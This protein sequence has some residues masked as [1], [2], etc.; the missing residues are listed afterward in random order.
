MHGTQNVKDDCTILMGT[1]LFNAGTHSHTFGM[2]TKIILYN[3]CEH[4][5]KR[6]EKK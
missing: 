6:K 1:S 2:G 5:E 4:F 3:A